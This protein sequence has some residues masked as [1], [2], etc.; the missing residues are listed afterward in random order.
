MIGFDIHNVCRVSVEERVV[1]QG[2]GGYVVQDV[3]VHY[4]DNHHQG[5]ELRLTLYGL[6]S[7]QGAMS[8]PFEF[9]KDGK[10]K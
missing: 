4:M 9:A 8:I 7:L 6:H 1:Q 10:G 2:E 5:Q 3:R